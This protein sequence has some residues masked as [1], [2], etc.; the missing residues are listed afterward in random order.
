[1][2]GSDHPFDSGERKKRWIIQALNECHRNGFI[3]FRVIM[4]KVCTPQHLISQM[5][6]RCIHSFFFETMI[7]WYR[8]QSGFSNWDF[9]E[10]PFGPESQWCMKL[11]HRCIVKLE[12]RLKLQQQRKKPKPNTTYGLSCIYSVSV[13]LILYIYIYVQLGNHETEENK[14]QLNWGE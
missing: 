13:I 3:S 8:C 4:D 12:Q 2:N 5:I 11:N 1:M 7:D 6:E 9:P 14:I 10:Y